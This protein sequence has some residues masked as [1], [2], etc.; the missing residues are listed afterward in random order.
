MR[1]GRCQAEAPS[2]ALFCPA[3]GTALSVVCAACGSA[4]APG[5]RFCKRCGQPLNTAGVGAVTEQPADAAE[6][7]QL[8]VMFCDLVG[9]T[10]LSTR[11]DP[12]RLR[13][14]VRAYQQAAAGQIDRF[15]GHVAQYL[16]DGLL[17]YFGYPR[18]HE[19]DAQRAVRAALA[20]VEA[21]RALGARHARDWG[22]EPVVRL[23]IHTGPVVVGEMGSGARFE[24]LALGETPNLA[25]RLQTMAEPNTV[26]ISATSH[27]LLRGLFPCQD[28]G[29]Q[30]LKGVATPVQAYRVLGE[31]QEQARREVA[32][33]AASPLVGRHE[34]LGL[35][36]S[37]WEQAKGGGQVVLLS[38][39]PGIGKSRLVEALGEQI[40]RDPHARW[41]CRCSP[42]HQQS[43]LRPWIEMAERALE[44]TREDDPAQRLHK[45]EARLA[46]YGLADP[47]AIDLWA[48]LLSVLRAEDH[49]PLALSP[50]RLRQKTFDAIAR[51][52]LAFAARSPVLLVVEDLHWADPSTLEL[53][54]VLI[55]QVATAR[56]LLLL[57]A[58]PEFR[59]PWASR[60]HTTG[61]ALARLA[62]PQAREIIERLSG[63]RSLPVPVL[64]QIAKRSDGVPLF[65]EE[66]TKAVLEASLPSDGERA[67]PLAIPATLQDSLM[68]RL[69]RLGSARAVAQLGATIGRQFSFELLQAVSPHGEETLE[70]ELSRLVDAELLYQRG[71]A[72]R[73]T[74]V[75][76][77]ALIQEAAYESLLRSTRS[78]HHQ[79][80]AAV[81]AER[82]PETIET[83]PEL[84]AQHLSAAG[85]LALAVEYWRRAGLLAKQRSANREAIH[86]FERALEALGGLAESPERDQTEIELLTALGPV[87]S[88]TGGWGAA[89]VGRLYERA[90]DLC[91]RAGD[92]PQLFTALWGLWFYDI[93]SGQFQTALKLGEQ[94][95][96]LAERQPDP[97]L[98]MQAHHMLGPTLLTVGALPS[99]RLHFEAAIALYD[100]EKHRSHAS[101]YG[102]HD[103]C[104]CCS[105]VGALAHWIL[106]SP[107]LALRRAR[108]AIELARKLEH[109]ASRVHALMFTAMLH[110]LRR[111]PDAARE[112]ATA[113]LTIATEYDLA[114]QAIWCR[115]M[116]AWAVARAGLRGEGLAKMQKN[117]AVVNASSSKLWQP[118]F[119]GMIAEVCDE[120]EWFEVGLAALDEGLARTEEIGG[121]YYEAELHRL[122]G[123][124]LLLR[125][126]AT[127]R[128]EA[129]ACFHRALELAREK[130]ARSWQL[131]AAMSLVR[132]W[133]G[134][135]KDADAR[136]LLAEVY[137]GFT[138]GFDTEDLKGAR[139]L[140][141]KTSP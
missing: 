82:F 78:Q 13:E 33:A 134:S 14:V 127:A 66:L 52:L 36:L 90:R 89:E 124:L 138:E 116:Q 136:G 9:S 1:C 107:D 102:G 2:D 27:R 111:D 92:A 38:G 3:C 68:A 95:M 61:A 7:R 93:S 104:V 80:I 28:L 125:D 91:G 59:P 110:Q 63:E 35:L 57:T 43:A 74:Y 129:D 26:L 83:Q 103:P 100:P 71:L 97:G 15:E 139:R 106:G 94:L 96:S 123:E 54:G 23:G 87:M 53:L 81:L 18:A 126:R 137:A 10:E 12:E 141:A 121:R 119:L 49:P 17:V 75:F 30:A 73:A 135:E 98:L 131:R 86:H 112:I 19:D 5:D 56:V 44:F 47:E 76:K 16:G 122:R 58:R 79:R 108:E 128:D 40:A 8:T 50:Q 69:D 25:A 62:L 64:D 88:A 115:F 60:S 65:V 85:Q 118:H 42:Y 55:D 11:L 84:L 132:L 120:P 46:A 72:P 114:T 45:I 6:R 41:E 51:L 37:R 21:M 130:E 29:A 101:L 4:H 77:H 20:I 70:R 22:Y 24:Q 31:S 34:E 109:P 99:A 32:A 105:A 48:M 140:L 67:A 133:H 113:G 117:W 39:E